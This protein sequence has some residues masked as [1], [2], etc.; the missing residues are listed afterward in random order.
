MSDFQINDHI[1]T[2]ECES[3]AADIFAEVLGELESDET[4]D[5]NRYEMFDRANEVVDGH[6][7]IIYNYRALMLCAHCDVS[8]GEAFLQD[9]GMPNDV[10]IHKLA[11]LIAYG[12]MHFRVCRALVDLIESW[13]LSKAES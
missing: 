1:L 2:K 12:E 4:P 7:W 5:G 3:L 13:D 9:V 8:E 11:C 6:E 10:T